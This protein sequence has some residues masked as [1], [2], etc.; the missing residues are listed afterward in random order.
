MVAILL[1]FILVF[2]RRSG[3]LANNADLSKVDT[4]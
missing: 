3:I 1:F 4:R 2:F